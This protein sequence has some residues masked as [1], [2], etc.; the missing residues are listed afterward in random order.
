V[1]KDPILFGGHQAN[2]Y[3]YVRNDPVN[4]TDPSGLWYLDFNITGGAWV[5]VTGGIFLDPSGIH[6]YLGG[7][8]VTPGVCGSINY[9]EWGSV[10]PGAWSGQLA[11]SYSALNL[12][13]GY[14]GG[15]PFFEFGAGFP[16]T[17]GGSLT[18]YYTW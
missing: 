1:S 8:A 9:S 4:L 2:L 5:G 7:G 16:F 10:S 17:P 12:A 18:G 13:G 3:V 15:S 6:P 11:G 14:G